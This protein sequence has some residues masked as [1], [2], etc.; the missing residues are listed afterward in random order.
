[1]FTRDVV[2]DIDT[3]LALFRDYCAVEDVPSDA[4]A[5]KLML[6]PLERKLAIVVDADSW[7]QDMPPLEVRFDIKRVYGGV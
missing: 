6:H 7:A 2:V 1:M 4:R 3:L 5:V